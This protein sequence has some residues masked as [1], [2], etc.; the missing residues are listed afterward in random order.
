M[1]Y[2]IELFICLNIKLR[3]SQ[4]FYHVCVKHN[5][6]EGDS[7]CNEIALV[8]SSTHALELYTIYGMKDQSFTFQM[9][10][11]TLF[12]RSYLSSYRRLKKVR[13][14]LYENFQQYFS[15]CMAEIETKILARFLL[16]LAIITAILQL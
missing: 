16:F 6:Y 1:Q 13:L 11:K 3:S 8:T 2:C 14:S 9:V 10:H 7:I 4:L 15:Y 12:F 5:I